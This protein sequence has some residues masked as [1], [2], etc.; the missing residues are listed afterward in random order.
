MDSDAT[1]AADRR[2][3]AVFV[4]WGNEDPDCRITAAQSHYFSRS[5]V[6]GK[7]DIAF[8]KRG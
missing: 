3:S 6:V 7:S 8:A 1:V 5:P 4:T 2:G